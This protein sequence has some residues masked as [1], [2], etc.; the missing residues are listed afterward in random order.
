MKE[1]YIGRGYGALLYNLQVV[2]AML[3]CSMLCSCSIHFQH[4]QHIA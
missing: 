3:C 4:F 2:L 1:H